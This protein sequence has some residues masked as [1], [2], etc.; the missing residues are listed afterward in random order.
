LPTVP[1]GKENMEIALCTLSAIN[2]G[3]I[4]N[5]HELDPICDLVVRFL[6]NILDL[7]HYPVEQVQITSQ[8]RRS[9][10]IGV[11]NFA[12]FL[13]KRGYKYG[14]LEARNL[15][16]EM[17][18][19]LQYYLLQASANLAKEK[20]PCAKFQETKY[21]NGILP[22]DNY[23]H[24]IDT[25]HNST[26]N[27][28]WEQLR[29]KIAKF[30]L[31]NSTLSAQM[32]CESSSVI[33][34]STNGIEA[35]RNYIITKVSKGGPIKMVLEDALKLSTSYQMLWDLDVKDAL[36]LSGIMQKFFDQSIS[37][38]THYDPSKY[39]NNLVPISDIL[40][41]ILFAYKLGIKTLYYHNTREFEPN[42][43]GDDCG[44]TI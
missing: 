32:P 37:T 8:Q 39:K 34:N 24:F 42:T 19:A 20:G 31:R 23:R 21:S 43:T 27:L 40:G 9:L 41:D 12:Y 2:L 25:F 29:A 11:T 1:V 36:V 14:S 4:D 35:P 30:G 33:S 7:Q 10:G 6:D 16:H 26:L 28:P 15:T 18:E 17:S 13:A 3:K 44:C 38:N 5:L 22:I